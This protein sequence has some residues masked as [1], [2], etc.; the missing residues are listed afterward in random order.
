MNKA[1]QAATATQRVSLPRCPLISDD[2]ARAHNV[3]F[4]IDARFGRA[5]RLLQA[6]WLKDQSIPTGFHTRGEGE[7]AVTMELHSNLSRDAA[8]AGRNFLTPEIHKFTRRSVIMAE[9]GAAIDQERLFGNALSS[10]PLCFNLFGPLAMD[11]TLATEVFKRLYPSFV[12][13]VNEII[14][15]HSPGRR[16]PLG[17]DDQSQNWMGDRTAWDVVLHITTPQ[18]EPG[19]IHTEVKF[20]EDCSASPAQWRDKYAEVSRAVRLYTDPDSP[21]LKKQCNQYFREHSMSQL[22]VDKGL[23]AKAMFLAI[24]PRLNRRVMASFK[25]YE[26]ELIPADD[27]DDNRVPFVALTLENLIAAIGD[28]GAEELARALW[29]RYADF[30]RVYQLALSEFEISPSEASEP[31]VKKSFVARS[32]AKSEDEKA[33]TSLRAV[34]KVAR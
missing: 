11:L 25:M 32:R 23:A 4:A 17:I 15:E 14:F 10:M 3:Y 6:L 31:S 13:Q 26:N 12:A 18:N 29:A 30:E 28:A 21:M 1:N 16:D 8:R 22:V 9:P 7:N 20:S 24:G 33:S 19:V 27:R 34:H 5:A 2:L